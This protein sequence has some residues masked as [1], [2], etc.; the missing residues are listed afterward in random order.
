[1]H[2]RGYVQQS[3]QKDNRINQNNVADL[4][5]HTQFSRQ[6]SYTLITSDLKHLHPST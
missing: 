3:V 4:V 6:F 1:M 2:V 5:G